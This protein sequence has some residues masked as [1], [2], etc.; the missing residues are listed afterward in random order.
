ME[1]PGHDRRKS[2]SVNAALLL[3]AALIPVLGAID[4]SGID[5][6]E[7]RPWGCR[8]C[9]IPTPPLPVAEQGSDPL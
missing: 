1:D 4:T 3:A 6:T 8:T 2:A 7:V 9:T 5:H